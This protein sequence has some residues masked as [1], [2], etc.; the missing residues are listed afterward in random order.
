MPTPEGFDAPGNLGDGDL[1][2]VRARVDAPLSTLGLRGGRATA[3]LSYIGTRVEDPYT[4]RDRPFSGTSPLVAAF[5]L[6]QDRTKF[7]WGVDLEAILP[8][9]FYRLNEIDESS[10]GLPYVGVFAE[11][12]PNKR[13][14]ITFGVDNLAD[15]PASRRRTFFLPDRR[16]PTPSLFE[17]RRRNAHVQPYLTLKHQF[18]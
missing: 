3:Y 12:R 14:T 2:L 15:R 4:G 16:N 9:R 8:T 5:S 13:S 6:R 11:Y 17:F 7:A 18:G 1:W 10:P